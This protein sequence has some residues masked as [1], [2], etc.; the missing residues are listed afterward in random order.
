MTEP[1]PAG[2]TRPAVRGRPPV[3]LMYHGFCTR[4]RPDDP[5]NLFVEVGRFEQ[6]LRWML[7]QGWV[8]LDLDGYLA[9]LA[10]PAG[11]PRRSFLVTIDDGFTSVL[12]LAVPVL[13]RLGVPA[14][15]YVPSDLAGRTAT[16]LPRP[17]EEPLLDADE[18]RHLHSLPVVELGVHGADHVDLR[19]VGATALDHQVRAA[20][21]RLGELVGAPLR[22]FAYPFGA[23]DAAAR[24]AVARE[25]FEVGFSVFDDAGRHAVSRVDVNATDS[26]ASFRLK[27]QLPGY[28]QWWSA[29]DRAPFVRRGVRAALTTLG[30]RQDDR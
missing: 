8:A 27:V 7:D 2:R 15:L 20:H 25:G 17:G 10:D 13:E 12:H 26:L 23:H 1:G 6:Q 4:R 24:E 19:G 11:R 16:W 14:L 22:S 30:G 5:E 21:G 18:L 28:R 9:A 29:L 3:V